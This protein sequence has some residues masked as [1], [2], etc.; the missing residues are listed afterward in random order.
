MPSNSIFALWPI[1][2][3]GAEENNDGSNST[4]DTSGQS[5]GQSSNQGGQG[6]SNQSQTKGD[7]GDEDDPYKGLSTKEL[8][9]L[10]KDAEDK[11][12]TVEQ[13]LETLRT[14]KQQAEDAKLDENQR[15]DKQIN[16][17]TAENNTLRASLAKAAIV[18][19]INE[20][21]QYAWNSANIVAQQLDS[22]KVKVD[23]KGKVTGLEKELARIATDESLKFLLVKDN[24]GTND[25][26]NNNDQQQQQQNN[27]VTGF[28]PGQGG[29]TTAGA[30]GGIDATQAAELA[31]KMPA[32][33]SR[34]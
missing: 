15:K 10:L 14:E 16:D 22:E 21:K 30:I 8:K 12:T 6:N 11:G 28:Q 26:N 3:L 20:N 29:A 32:L 1:V 34:L 13:E 24:S 4:T 17:L 33:A 5:G 9:K 27:G 2:P 7:D 19:A 23:D 31:K 25:G 18:N